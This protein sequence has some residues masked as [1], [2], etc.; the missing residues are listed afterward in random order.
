M[1]PAAAAVATLQIY[2]C[3]HKWRERE[4]YPRSISSAALLL[5]MTLAPFSFAQL[6]TSALYTNHDSCALLLRR[7]Q[8]LEDGGGGK[9]SLGHTVPGEILM[10]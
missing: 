7:S 2:S 6:C 10:R 3:V 9:S 8:A 1:F 4:W 5:I